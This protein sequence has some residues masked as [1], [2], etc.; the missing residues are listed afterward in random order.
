MSREPL[1]ITRCGPNHN[2][3]VKEGGEREKEEER[4]REEWGRE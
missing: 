3:R 1:S 2:D 4:E